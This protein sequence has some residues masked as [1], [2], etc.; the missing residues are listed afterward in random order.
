MNELQNENEKLKNICLE[1]EQFKKSMV[2]CLKEKD[3]LIS[4]Y[5]NYKAKIM[6]KIVI[7]EDELATSK[8]IIGKLMINLVNLKTKNTNLKEELTLNRE[9]LNEVKYTP[10]DEGNEA[11]QKVY[12]F[13]IRNIIFM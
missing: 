10:L 11:S 9:N 6:K 3:E 13:Y 5:R 8:K 12:K 2:I 4:K 1:Y 7:K